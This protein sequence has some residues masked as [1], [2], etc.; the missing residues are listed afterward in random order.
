M[1][2]QND[3]K[4]EG[5][6]IEPRNSNLLSIDEYF[7]MAR[8]LVGIYLTILLALV[9]PFAKNSSVCFVNLQFGKKKQSIP[10]K[11]D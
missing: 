8:T 2:R 7:W 5:W 4:G 1:E 9:L 11:I 6:N 10:C 3:E